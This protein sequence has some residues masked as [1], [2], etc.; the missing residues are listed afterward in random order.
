[1]TGGETLLKANP[2]IPEKESHM[3]KRLPL[4]VKSCL[5]KAR[6]SAL[7]AVET[8]NKPAVKFKSGG[9]IVLMCIAWTSLFHAIFFNKKIKP[10]YKDP[11]N[12]R[13]YLRRAGDIQFWELETCVKNYF[14]DEVSAMRKNIEFFIPLRNMLEHRF[15]PELDPDI[16]AECEALLLNFDKILNKEFGEEYM[17]RE[18]L[19]F[20]LQLFP[21]SKTLVAA[22]KETKE[23]RNI[24]DFI[25]KYRSAITTD[26][27]QSGEYSFK[28]FLFQVANHK[29]ADS[30]PIQFYSFDNMTEEEKKNAERIAALVKTKQVPVANMGTFKPGKVV[31]LVQAGLGYAK[32]TRGTKEVDK[33]NMTTHTRCWKHYGVRPENGSSHPEMTN[34]LYCIYD[35]PN[36]SYLF[37]QAWIDFLIEKLSDEVEYDAVNQ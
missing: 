15:M 25:Q 9:Y 2:D 37:T 24:I 30:L 26:M 10:F 6:D 34:S 33:F 19:S 28:A 1:M 29:S 21:S 31:E 32:V 13:K 8:Y 22:V 17:L 23:S 27:L 4:T 5:D 14:K 12:K 36:N 16:F 3:A 35:E 7:L 18:T 20:A 11:K